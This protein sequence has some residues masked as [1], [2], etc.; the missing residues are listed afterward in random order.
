MPQ[1]PPPDAMSGS[2]GSTRR[3][4]VSGKRL[5][6]SPCLN[7]AANASACREQCQRAGSSCKAFAWSS[8]FDCGD[9]GAASGVCYLLSQVIGGLYDAPAASP[10]DCAINYYAAL[11]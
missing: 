6:A 2:C 5:S 8:P 7:R 10:E 3:K 11:A 4:L 1:P 9:D